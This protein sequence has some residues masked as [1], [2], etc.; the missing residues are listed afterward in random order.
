[1]EKE[2]ILQK[3]EEKL[4]PHVTNLE[5]GQSTEHDFFPALLWLLLEKEK[6]LENLLQG[7]VTHQ[8]EST[9][10]HTSKLDEVAQ[11]LSSSHEQISKNAIELMLQR[12]EEVK[13]NQGKIQKNIGIGILVSV[14]FQVIIL[15]LLGFLLMRTV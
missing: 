8:S 12:I 14:S 2:K 15:V 6:S 13:S 10:K 3:I 7:V 5:K 4:S 1:M 11:N 9:E